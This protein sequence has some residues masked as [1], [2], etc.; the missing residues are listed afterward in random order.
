MGR[1]RIF[2]KDDA[3]WEIVESLLEAGCSGT[4]IAGYFGVDQRCLYS[5]CEDFKGIPWSEYKM[6][7]RSKGK[8][9]IRL[10]QF[11]LAV[12]SK[13]ADMLKWLGKNRLDQTEKMDQHINFKCDPSKW[14]DERLEEER[15]K[16]I[17]V[18]DTSKELFEEV[19]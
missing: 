3:K 10:S 5:S 9:M 1:N 12:N 6:I 8:A 16:L 2:K 19:E 7:H 17:A 11:D 4:E 13:N 15:S 18:T 14:S